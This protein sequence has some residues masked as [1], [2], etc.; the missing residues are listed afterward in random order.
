M[1]SVFSRIQ[2]RSSLSFLPPPCYPQATLRPVMFFCPG[3]MCHTS[4]L[5]ILQTR[6]YSSIPCSFF[7][8]AVP[9]LLLER[10]FLYLLAYIAF[11]SPVTWLPSPPTIDSDFGLAD[12]LC[13]PFGTP[14]VM[15][16]LSSFTAAFV[17]L[18]QRFFVFASP[19]PLFVDGPG[20]CACPRVFRLLHL[21]AS[22][23]A[24]LLFFFFPFGTLILHL[25]YTLVCSFR[26]FLPFLFPP[27][28]PIFFFEFA[29][30]PSLYHLSR[31]LLLPF[32]P[33]AGVRGV[34]FFPGRSQQM[35]DRFHV[36]LSSC[37][38]LFFA[39]G[40]T[41]PFVVVWLWPVFLSPQV[42]R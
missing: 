26:G 5:T 7:A 30:P 40:F 13:S 35:A 8:L 42:T 6:V 29:P 28:S 24:L 9:L 37:G 14:R 19:K 18:S 22:L 17:H 3:V 32:C 1:Q 15:R 36:C 16:S 11:F 12:V 2:Q 4:C 31:Y 33:P 39:F 25:L 20:S 10:F 34:F 27:P 41:V 38:F 21:L 23:I